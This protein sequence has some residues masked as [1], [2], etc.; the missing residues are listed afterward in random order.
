MDNKRDL[1]LIVV[2]SLVFASLL[3]TLSAVGTQPALASHLN[4]RMGDLRLLESSGVIPI[5]GHETTGYY[6]MG[7]LRLIEAQG[8]NAVGLIPVTAQMENTVPN[9]GMGDLHYFEFLQANQ[10][11]K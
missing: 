8:F 4:P 7:K 11:D 5:T 10:L 2:V 1:R 9:G 3:F 6:A